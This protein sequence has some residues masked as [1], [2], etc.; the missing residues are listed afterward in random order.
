MSMLPPTPLA[1]PEHRIQ[2]R[3]LLLTSVWKFTGLEIGMPTGTTPPLTVSTSPIRMFTPPASG[4]MIGF[5]DSVTAVPSGRIRA[6]R[7]RL[8]ERAT[9]DAK[10][11]RH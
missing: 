11:I 4:E 9:P 10:L 5:C 8:R 6:P 1:R 2:I 7:P 3:W